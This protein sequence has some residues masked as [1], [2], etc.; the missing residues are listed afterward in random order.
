MFFHSFLGDSLCAAAFLRWRRGFGRHRR[1]GRRRSGL[2]GGGLG[3]ADPACFVDQ[4]Q[5][6]AEPCQQI[7][8]GGRLAAV[9]GAL[10]GG[11]PSL[12]EGRDD[13][14]VE[15]RSARP[16]AVVI[17]E[18]IEF[19]VVDFERGVAAALQRV[20]LDKA[21]DVRNA[22]ARA[23]RHHCDRRLAGHPGR[24]GLLR[25]ADQ[26]T[27]PA[28]LVSRSIGRPRSGRAERTGPRRGAFGGG[29]IPR[30][31][32]GLAACP[33]NGTVEKS[34]ARPEAPRTHNQARFMRRA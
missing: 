13:R 17:C 12:E 33:G 21:D 7:G 11:G 8:I 19:L 16:G 6:L 9:R 5:R 31:L 4:R 3:A 24:I 34:A 30:L 1:R 18:Q 26:V 20:A 2:R 15:F 25:P 32:L 23:M 27:D 22:L 14:A 10:D 28:G 29:L